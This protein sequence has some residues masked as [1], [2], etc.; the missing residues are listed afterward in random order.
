[1][2]ALRFLGEGRAAE[3]AVGIE[4][5]GV[6]PMVALRNSQ[7]L[8]VRDELGRPVSAKLVAA[9]L[10]AAQAAASADAAFSS[11][12]PRPASW[13]GRWSSGSSAGR[14]RH[15]LADIALAR[16]LGLA[17]SQVPIQRASTNRTKGRRQ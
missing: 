11:R 16:A 15:R 9:Q 13:R 10:K 1:M 2:R 5:Q 12:L 8:D 4:A 3:R 14:H 6:D 17:R 7:D